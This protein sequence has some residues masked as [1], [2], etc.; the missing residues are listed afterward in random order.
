MGPLVPKRHIPNI[1]TSLR[2]VLALAAVAALAARD[3]TPPP[4][5][6]S[7]TDAAALNPQLAIAAILFIIAA[8]TDALDGHLARRWNVISRFG[9]VMDPLADKLLVLGTFVM[10]AGPN[11]VVVREGD[12]V[13][14]SPVAAWMAV[15]IITRELL[16]TSLR[17]VLE[18]QGRDFSATLSGKLKMILQS[19]VVPAIM[20]T[21]L[22]VSPEQGT[23]V[24]FGLDI[25]MW[26]TVLV[27][28]ASGVPYVVRAAKMA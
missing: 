12:P 15:I 11:F 28:I 1:L 24:R 26:I 17:G 20:L 22:L 16:V 7:I 4:A 27:T 9:R 18:A 6:A 10:L 5:Q 8:L 2:V 13:T 19:A 23:K 3:Y 14:L 25:A 21:M